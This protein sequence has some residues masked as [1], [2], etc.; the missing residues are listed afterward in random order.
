MHREPVATPLRRA[1][2]SFLLVAACDGGLESTRG[3]PRAPGP[4]DSSVA[5]DPLVVT[6]G[7]LQERVLLTGEVDAAVSVELAVPR[8]DD[9]SI[10]IRW[11]ADE[12][13]VVEAGGRVVEFDNS[14]VVERI[15]ELELAMV[16]AL[17]ELEGKRAE[18][19]VATEDKRFEVETEKVALAQA[20]LDASVPAELVSR[21]EA[22]DNQL[23]L[24]RAE[25]ALAAASDDLRSTKDGG[26]MQEQVAR[27]AHD[28]A[29][30]ALESAEQQL[31]ALELRAPQG[32]LMVVGDHPWEGR[33]L[34]VGDVVWPGM[35]VA[36]LPDLSEMLVEAALSDVDEGRIAL[37]MRASCRVDAFPDLPIE[38]YV[39]GMSPVAHQAASQASRR[40]FS[41]VIALDGASASRL[42]QAVL[43][44]GLSV[45][46]EVLARHADDALLVPRAALD[47]SGDAVRARRR[48]DTEVEVVLDFCDAH[49][50]A[51]VSGL[52]EGDLLES[53]EEGGGA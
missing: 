45:E 5:A 11:M 44:P 32:G 24:A 7:S 8:T 17:T 52:S 23:A 1:V 16:E 21:R 27:I 28:K 26:A 34:Q 12:G 15:G 14:G 41:V 38:G 25:A 53:V 30:R 33:K 22:R 9:W 36:R 35:T 39:K 46:V 40:F 29:L 2:L 51:V 37:G 13:T 49:R 20:R 48:G 3:L 18:N 50:C 6:R 19:A 42:G 43:R 31:E 10:S 47:M 4:D